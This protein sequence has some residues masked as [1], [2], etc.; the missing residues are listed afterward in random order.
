MNYDIEENLPHCIK[1]PRWF[2]THGNVEAVDESN[3]PG[4]LRAELNRS[5]LRET[6]TV[7]EDKLLQAT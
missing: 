6:H 5:H 7:A 3:I 1:Q 4:N 2:F